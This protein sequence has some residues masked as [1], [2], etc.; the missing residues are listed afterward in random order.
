LKVKDTGCGVAK[1]NLSRV[2][3]PYFTTKPDGTGLGLAMSVKIIEEHGGTISFQS[4]CD[5]GTT[6]TVI[7][8][9]IGSGHV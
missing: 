4:D 1:E 5:S 2:F 9:V 3:D 7:L 6:V 8:P